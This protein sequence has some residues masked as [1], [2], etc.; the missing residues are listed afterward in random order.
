[1]NNNHCFHSGPGTPASSHIRRRRR[2]MKTAPLDVNYGSTGA[3]TP[4]SSKATG[5]TTPLL[6]PQTNDYGYRPPGFGLALNGGLKLA[7]APCPCSCRTSTAVTPQ[8]SADQLLLSQRQSANA[9]RKAEKSSMALKVDK[10]SSTLFPTLF[11][12]FNI[13]YWWYYLG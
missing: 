7:V 11:C 8:N 5:P 12:L 6:L 4:P 1:M 13:F 2:E 10:V 3:S 9:A